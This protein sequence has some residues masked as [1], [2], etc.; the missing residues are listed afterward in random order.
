LKHL[1][2]GLLLK[3]HMVLGLYHGYSECGG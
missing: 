2:V 1:H 3:L